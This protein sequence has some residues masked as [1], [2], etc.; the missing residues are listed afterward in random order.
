MKSRKNTIGII[1][2][3]GCITAIVALWL[4]GPRV[5]NHVGWVWQNTLPDHVAYSGRTYAPAYSGQ[6]LTQD[7]AKQTLVN[8]RDGFVQV[9]SVPALFGTSAPLFVESS[10]G[11]NPSYSLSMEVYVQ[12]NVG[13]YVFYVIEGGP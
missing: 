1:L 9:E 4:L 12:K 8:P 5:A 6:C 10:N 11:K 13:C 3:L 2:L 7:G